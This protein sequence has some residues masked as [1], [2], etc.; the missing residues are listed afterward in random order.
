[1]KNKAIF[2][3]NNGNL[4]LLCSSCYKIIK[5][6]KDFTPEEKLACQGKL[7]MPQQRCMEC[8]DKIIAKDV[9]FNSFHPKY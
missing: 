3:F 8:L 6:G 2:K 7:Y 1:M 4:A 9:E 5:E